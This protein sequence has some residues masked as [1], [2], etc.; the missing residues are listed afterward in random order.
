MGQIPDGHHAHGATRRI[1]SAQFGRETLGDEVEFGLSRFIGER[2]DGDRNRPGRSGPEKPPARDRRHHYRRRRER[3]FPPGARRDQWPDV[4]P[5]RRDLRPEIGQQRFNALVPVR[6]RLGHGFGD[7]GIE[8]SRHIRHPLTQRG[9]RLVH[10]LEQHG[11]Q[12][13]IGEG[14]LAGDHLVGHAAEGV[15][16]GAAID[17]LAPDHLGRHVGRRADERVAV[18]QRRFVHDPGGAEVAQFHRAVL[19]QKHVGRFEIPVNDAAGVGEGQRRS[20]LADDPD[21]GGNIQRPPPLHQ[22]AQRLAL[23]IL[24]DDGQASVVFHDVMHGDDVAVL[25]PRRSLSLTQEAL[26]RL[27]AFA[28]AE[29]ILAQHLDANRPFQPPVPRVKNLTK[30]AAAQPAA[31]FVARRDAV[32]LADQPGIIRGGR[33]RHWMGVGE[34]IG[35]VPVHGPASLLGRGRILTQGPDEEAGIP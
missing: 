24:H 17:G 6:R 21:R 23:D 8:P 26:R 10:H 11:H 25:E 34:R 35:L 27:V 5:G 7:G 33:R 30:A 13:G 3:P 28:V 18:G 14:P 16:I 31:D 32:G 29:H 4:C 22:V 19:G 1:E 20:D 9:R 15:D 12:V 2:H